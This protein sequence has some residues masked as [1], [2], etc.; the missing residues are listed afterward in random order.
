MQPCP[1][2]PERK[3]TEVFG[4][5]WRHPERPVPLLSHPRASLS[6]LRELREITSR[7]VGRPGPDG[8]TVEHMPRRKRP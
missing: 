5:L 8:S 6:L 4:I 7:S 1:G 2:E 3:L